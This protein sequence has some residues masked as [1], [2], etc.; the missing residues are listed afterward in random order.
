[1]LII[2]FSCKDYAIIVPTEKNFKEKD[3]KKSYINVF[4]GL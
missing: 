1:M 3:T 2:F 4:N